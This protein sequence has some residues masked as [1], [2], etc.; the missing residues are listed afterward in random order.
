[1]SQLQQQ[2]LSVDMNGDFDY[3]V[4]MNTNITL[5]KEQERSLK[6]VDRKLKLDVVDRVVTQTL[7]ID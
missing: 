6:F 5:N 1:M 7:N 2:C 3:V 4:D